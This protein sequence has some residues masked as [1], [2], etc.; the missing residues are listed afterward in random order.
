MHQG[1]A[2]LLVLRSEGADD[3]THHHPQRNYDNSDEPKEA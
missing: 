1:L 2:L 3:N